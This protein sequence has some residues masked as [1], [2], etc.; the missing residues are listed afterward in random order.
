MTSDEISGSTQGYAFTIARYEHPDAPEPLL[1]DTFRYAEALQ[2]FGRS[3]DSIS[4]YTELLGR[5]LLHLLDR[6]RCIALYSRGT[7]YSH[8]GRKQEALKDFNEACVVEVSPV[9]LLRLADAITGF[10]DYEKA[11][12]VLGDALNCEEATQDKRL[13]IRIL[14]AMARNHAA[15]G[16]L[17][18]ARNVLKDALVLAPKRRSLKARLED[19]RA[20]IKCRKEKVASTDAP[21]DLGPFETIERFELLYLGKPAPDSEVYHYVEALLDAD[22][23]T[24]ALEVSEG[25]QDAIARSRMPGNLHHAQELH[26]RILMELGRLPEAEIFMRQAWETHKSE[27][28]VTC[29]AQCLI[30]QERFAEAEVVLRHALAMPEID[31]PRI[32]M[33]LALVLRADRRLAEAE[34][35]LGKLVTIAPDNE[36]ATQYLEDIRSA[37][38]ITGKG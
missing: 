24:A 37:I 21:S 4:V 16:K 7:S 8:L 6:A 28:T 31:P 5:D 26:G 35:I 25:W 27:P 23:Y 2:G 38:K 11:L 22:R 20:A 34:S 33:R 18:K 9:P 13:Y 12:E 29:L 19:I 3:S 10:E 15:Q 17:L 36:E 32:M 30:A 14:V 1:Q